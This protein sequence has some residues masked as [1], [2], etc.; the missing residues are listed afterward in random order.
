MGCNDKRLNIEA[1]FF[2]FGQW[3]HSQFLHCLPSARHKYP[4]QK[5]IY[6]I[7]TKNN[8]PLAY[9][10]FFPVS[11]YWIVEKA[12]CACPGMCI[13]VEYKCLTIIEGGILCKAEGKLQQPSFSFCQWVFPSSCCQQC[14]CFPWYVPHL[15]PIGVYDPLLPIFTK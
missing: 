3:S 5:H 2:C 12:T 15:L 8:P 1:L 11:V 10:F 4:W 14:R 7:N 13:D 6:Y 9:F